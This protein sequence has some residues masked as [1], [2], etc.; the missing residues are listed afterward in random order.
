MWYGV[1]SEPLLDVLK[2]SFEAFAPCFHG[3]VKVIPV[4]SIIECR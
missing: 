2:Y 1:I 3:S 4:L